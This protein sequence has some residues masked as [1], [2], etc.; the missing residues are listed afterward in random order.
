MAGWRGCGRNYVQTLFVAGHGRAVGESK[1][2][3]MRNF[4]SIER[5]GRTEASAGQEKVLFCHVLGEPAGGEELP[6][7][8]NLRRS[9]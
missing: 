9:V 2:D 3:E 7:A 1:T 5:T 4:V 8:T 6:D